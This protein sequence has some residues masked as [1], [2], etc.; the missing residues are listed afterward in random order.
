[1]ADPQQGPYAT[2]RRDPV[3]RIAYRAGYV[4]AAFFV[5]TGALA[6]LARTPALALF[7]QPSPSWPRLRE[8]AAV[9]MIAAGFAL[10]NFLRRRYTVAVAASAL[11]VGVTV[12]AMIAYVGGVALPGDGMSLAAAVLLFTSS[13]AILLASARRRLLRE[14]AAIGIA[15]FV[16][17]AVTITFLIARAAALIDPMS[18]RLVA[19]LALQ[20]YLGS[21]A[22]GICFVTLAWS[23]G[24][25]AGET[26]RWLPFALGAAG[27]VTVLVLWRAL[28]T[29]EIDQLQSLT[30]Q[31]A[32]ER[33]RIL[34][35]EAIVGAR[36]LHR[37]AEW[38]A[39]GATI[40]QQRRDLFA[41]ARDLPG[42][43]S[44]GW[45][46]SLGVVD[47]AASADLRGTGADSIMLA[48]VNQ[49]GTLPDSI[50]YL[51]VDDGG[52]RFV[53]VSPACD[54]ARCAGA[55]VAVFG[56]AEFFRAALPDTSRGF[57][58]GITGRQGLIAG[59][60]ISA[61]PESRWTEW[62]AVD[63][64]T[65]DLTLTA[66]PTA[67]TISRVRSALPG[68]VLVLGL[69]VSTLVA[70]SATL[71][72]RTLRVARDAERARLATALERSTDGIWE[73]DIPSGRSLHSARIWS[74]LGYEPSVVP[75]TRAAWLELIHPEDAVR[76]TQE[77]AAYLAGARPTFESEYRVLA[78]DGS[79]HTIADR[80]SVVDRSPAGAPLQ[81]VGIKADITDSRAAQFAREAAERRFR[82][83]FDSGFQFQLLLDREGRVLEVNRHALEATHTVRGDVVG[84]SIADSLW[85]RDDPAA[86]E[87]LHAAIAAARNGGMR[88]YEE[89]FRGAGDAALNLEISIKAIP[90]ADGDEQAL[91]E[92]RDLTAFRRAE[93]ALREVETLTTMGRIAARVAH[94]INNPLAGIQNSFLLVKGAI[95][96]E[97]PHHKYVGAIE[98]E[99]ARIAA[100]TRQLYETYRPEQDSPSTTS[101]ATVIG[102]A[103]AFLEQVN[104][105]SD[106]RVVVELSHRPSV[107]ALPSVML[108]Q[109]V[110]NLVQNAIE[111]SPKGE[112]VHVRTLVQDGKFLLRVRDKGPGIP[113]DVREKIFEPFFTTKS[114]RIR[115]G[116]MGLGL[117]LVRRSVMA[118][119]GTIEIAD[120]EGGGCEFIVTLPLNPL[121]RGAA[122]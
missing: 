38:R 81:M 104:R 65:T 23:R 52:H 34:A 78:K 41:L 26:A 9:T 77:I 76:V 93:A 4:I 42:L 49:R 6:L 113:C 88:P 61:A 99:I 20:P 14:E 85:W 15:G 21:L 73:W 109:V 50:A 51:A 36:A 96:T 29:R 110:Y 69:I 87:R 30:R 16:L 105:A 64:G 24:L 75:G 43:Q 119:G 56:T 25:I 97:H 3:T 55:M 108:R 111:A 45:I 28:A 32:D 120:V 122:A 72:Q 48:Y 80:G 33:R 116:G 39:G 60:S 101:V 2:V 84:K 107:L 74:G 112:T 46:S 63:L 106:V 118:F 95:P 89:V 35:G 7:A 62:L 19:A 100:V 47:T 117:S 44:A 13:V 86:R 90:G 5:A 66:W 27:A 83:M 57:G 10:W 67:T 121:D 1:M 59:S 79:W 102:D 22:L 114:G 70:L 103:V 58:F 40:S 68:L 92:A 37:A 18:D 12:V 82:G 11:A 94:E 54:A 71:G 17:L 53:T 115:T 98:R 31:A 8:F 91:V